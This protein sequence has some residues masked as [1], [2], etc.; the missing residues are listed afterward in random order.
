[1]S[2]HLL[3]AHALLGCD[4]TS[5]IYGI[6]KGQALSKLRAL[7]QFRKEA[8]IF[9]NSVSDKSKIIEAGEHALASI[10]NRKQG[11]TLDELRYLK[12]SEKVAKSASFVQPRSQPPT[13]TAAKYHILHVYYQ[14]QVWKGDTRLK[15]ADWGWKIV[16]NKYKPVMIDIPTAP[17][18]LLKIVRCNCKTDQWQEAVAKNKIF[19]VL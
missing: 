3:F 7:P 5:S 1:M 18:N 14:V 12:F 19:C 15:P 17:E 4:T 11:N 10:Y 8:E 16:E 9:I 13:S 6:G 2:R